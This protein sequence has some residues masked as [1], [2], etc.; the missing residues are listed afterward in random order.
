MTDVERIIA[1][2]ESYHQF[3]GLLFHGR[4]PDAEQRVFRGLLDPGPRCTPATVKA[5]SMFLVGK[6]ATK[7]CDSCAAGHGYW[8]KCVTA[9]DGQGNPIAGGSCSNCIWIGKEE[10]CNLGMFTSFQPLKAYFRQRQGAQGLY[11]RQSRDCCRR[12]QRSNTEGRVDRWRWRQHIHGL[13]VVTDREWT[14]LES[15]DEVFCRM[16]NTRISDSRFSNV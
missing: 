13:D 11:L 5:T 2:D 7:E 14:S 16:S 10:E 12:D 4:D 8:K 3:I 9:E 1:E 15:Y 6:E